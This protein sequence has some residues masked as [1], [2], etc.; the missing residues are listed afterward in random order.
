MA[1]TLKV[2]QITNSRQQVRRVSNELNE[3]LVNAGRLSATAREWV[4]D[5]LA[6]QLANQAEKEVAVFRPLAFPMAR[7]VQNL[8]A[9]N[10]DFCDI[11]LGRLMKRNVYLVPK[12]PIREKVRTNYGLGS[13]AGL[14]DSSFSSQRPQKL[15]TS[16]WG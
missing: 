13:I 12:Y 11:F 15:S 6:K 1:V 5:V 7:V 14:T 2:G 10:P 3:L 16:G 4:M 8:V 9:S